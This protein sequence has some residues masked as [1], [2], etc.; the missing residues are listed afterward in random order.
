MNPFPFF[1]FF[2]FPRLAVLL[3]VFQSDF[4]A[5]A[6]APKFDQLPTERNRAGPAELPARTAADDVPPSFKAKMK[7]L[8]KLHDNR[9]TGL[10][11]VPIELLKYT[12]VARQRTFELIDE[13]W[14]QEVLPAEMCV[15]QFLFLYK[16]KGSAND[17]S[18]YRCLCL[19]S[20]FYKLFATVLLHAIQ[21]EIGD[22]YLPDQ[23]AGFRPGRSVRDQLLTYHILSQ[24]L[25]EGGKTAVT[26][27]C[28]YKAAF[29]TINHFAIDAALVK[30]GCSRKTRALVR[31]IYEKATAVAK[32]SD[33][34]IDIK[35]GCLQGC[36]LSPTLFC[37]VLA[38]TLEGVCMD[39]V[40]A[41]GVT[42]DY[43]A[44]A[45]DIGAMCNTVK[46]ATTT[47][48]GIA[49]ASRDKADLF[50][51]I[52]KTETS[53]I[54]PKASVGR[55]TAEEVSALNMDINC[56]HCN[57]AFF[58][59]QGLG[60]HKREHCQQ[61]RIPTWDRTFNIDQLVDVRGGPDCRWHLVQWEGCNDYDK[62]YHGVRP[63]ER[64]TPTWEPAPHFRHNMDD[65]GELYIDR[66]WRTH[67]TAMG[68]DR[69]RNNR[70]PGEHRCAD[71]NY[72]AVSDHGLKVHKGKAKKSGKCKAASNFISKRAERTV[73]RNKHQKIAAE[74]TPKVLIDG[75]PLVNTLSFK[76]LGSNM[77]QDAT[78][79][80]AIRVRLAQ[81][82]SRFNQMYHIWI[83]E[84]LTTESKINMYK[85][86]V[87][88]I[89]RHGSEAWD[90]NKANMK[91]IRGW[92]TSCLVT[93]TGREY[94]EEGNE[95][96]TSYDFCGDI[97]LKR[98]EYLGQILRLPADRLLRQAVT[99]RHNGDKMPA[100]SMFMD[101]PSTKT[102]DEIVGLA[103]DKAA[104]KK[105]C[106]DTF[107]SLT[108]TT[109]ATMAAA[110]ADPSGQG[111]AT[112]PLP[113]KHIPTT[114]AD[115]AE[116]AAHPDVFQ[117]GQWMHWVPGYGAYTAYGN[118]N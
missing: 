83:D 18:K 6:M 89:A 64:W 112:A 102:F 108:T 93:I 13:C 94:K 14:T 21:T 72:I 87:C 47:A 52:G 97:R 96:T 3:L 30:A 79:C 50:I 80:Q 67:P 113:H 43:L 32:D 41:G 81:G 69:G 34:I 110:A 92:N 29:D 56:E 16:N 33:I 68:R 106:G 28:D 37:L 85:V 90:L 60:T 9:A 71:C 100:G 26:V 107:P 27:W 54:A 19:L 116:V 82:R 51:N 25:L 42:C 36:V 20:H 78:T 17:T 66:Y 75:K 117:F 31:E 49:D 35:R 115:K 118:E 8:R 38:L 40:S 98:L 62:I 88:M 7:A 46:G 44:Y 111:Q 104:W 101:V 15:G 5:R 109:T 99:A 95:Y 59:L 24:L 84:N 23:Q 65:N 4:F 63:G 91:M 86:S 77:E 2:L 1:L 48:Q 55:A 10:D 57:K 11:G 114:E 73:R 76:Y 12:T 70:V 74:D 45:D 58:T 105:L 39:P 61:A 103:H 53:H 22:D